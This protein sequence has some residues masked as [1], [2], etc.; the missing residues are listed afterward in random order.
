MV[1]FEN[2]IYV[3]DPDLPWGPDYMEL[4]VCDCHIPASDIRRI[5]DWQDL[6]ECPVCGASEDNPK[7]AD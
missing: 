6:E 5:P 2:H 7:R 1:K 3:W 4:S